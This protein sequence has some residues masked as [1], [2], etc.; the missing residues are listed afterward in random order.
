[1]TRVVTECT[2]PRNFFLIDPKFFFDEIDS[3]GSFTKNYF[4]SRGVVASWFEV[5]SIDDVCVKIF[6]FSEN[7]FISSSSIATPNRSGTSCRRS[8]VPSLLRSSEPSS[9]SWSS[10]STRLDSFQNYFFVDI[11]LWKAADE[12]FIEKCFVFNSHHSFQN[13]SLLRALCVLIL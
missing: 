11:D 7:F 3:I 4:L 2:H 8:R 9:L 10:H 12:N 6:L 5:C 13:L 1:M